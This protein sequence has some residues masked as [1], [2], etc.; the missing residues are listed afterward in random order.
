MSSAFGH[1]EALVSQVL[2]DT[3]KRLR[4]LEGLEFGRAVAFVDQRTTF[5]KTGEDG[6][7]SEAMLR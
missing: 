1:P 6:R 2:E 4:V 7:V 3:V 5:S